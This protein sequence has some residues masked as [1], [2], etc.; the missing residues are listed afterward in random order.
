MSHLNWLVWKLLMPSINAI[1]RFGITRYFT[2]HT[3]W[4][5]RGTYANQSL[6][7]YSISPVVWCQILN[8]NLINGNNDD[9]CKFTNCKSRNKWHIFDRRFPYQGNINGDSRAEHQNACLDVGIVLLW[10]IGATI[11]HMSQQLQCTNVWVKNRL[12]QYVPWQCIN[13]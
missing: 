8:D 5:I 9:H 13:W 4:D 2:Q 7:P 6:N 3:Y 10:L 1:T 11:F 12:C